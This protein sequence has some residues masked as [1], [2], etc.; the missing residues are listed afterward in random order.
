MATQKT[1]RRISWDQLDQLLA[2]EEAESRPVRLSADEKDEVRKKLSGHFAK[3]AGDDLRDFGEGVK[4]ERVEELHVYRVQLQTLHERRDVERCVKPHS[5]GKLP[6]PRFT[7]ANVDPWQYKKP[8]PAAYAEARDEL[9][10]GESQA[11]HPCGT[12]SGTGQLECGKCRGE[13]R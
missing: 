6:A 11:G 2:R 7:E 1:Q 5:G 8:A 13:G 3:G 9:V 4:F 12:C 10:I